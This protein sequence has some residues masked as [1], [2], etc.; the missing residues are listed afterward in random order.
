MHTIA[1]RVAVLLC[2]MA[3]VALLPVVSHG[4]TTTAPATQ[5]VAVTPATKPAVPAWPPGKPSA[6]A[7]LPGKGLGQHD[8]LYAG[9]AK[10]RDIYIVRKG[11]IAWA[12]HD[13]TGKGEISDATLLSNGN[14]LFAHQFGVTLI[15]PDKKV[16]WNF[17][18]PEKSEIHTAQAIGSDRVLFIQNGP[19]PK[20]LVV[21]IVSGK[22]EKELPLTVK[23]PKSTHG[24]FRHARLT[25]AHG[26]SR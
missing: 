22:T 1:R 10:T 17:D 13:A 14:V 18:A 4:D 26:E 21:N 6:P 7:D 5:P 23:N 3:C 8:F 24:Q 20:L 19:E 25:D 16:L 11:Q 2:P 15:N 9:E 12:Y